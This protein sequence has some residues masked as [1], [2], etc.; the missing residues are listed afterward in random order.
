[1]VRGLEL[2]HRVA[3]IQA[4]PYLGYELVSYSSWK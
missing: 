1:M 3:W 4:S 2:G